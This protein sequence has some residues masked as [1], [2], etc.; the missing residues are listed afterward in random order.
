M[1]DC[2]DTRLVE[3]RPI[4][5]FPAYR[6]GDDGSI[7]SRY[8]REGIRWVLGDDWTELKPT[9]RGEGVWQGVFRKGRY[10]VT[11]CRDGK[12]YERTIHRVILETFVG[13]RPRGM[14]ACHRDDDRDNNRLS[15]LRWDTHRNNI[16]DRGKNG[17]NRP[18]ELNGS[19]K[20]K[21]ADIPD[22]FRLSGQGMYQRDIAKIYG[23]THTLI[24]YVLRR[25]LWK[26]VVI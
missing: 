5:G 7:W 21:E 14:E 8:C 4:P 9:L 26:H 22:I 1:P 6:A 16:A 15:N 3:Y 18:G 19:A 13:P 23:V 2:D 25:R 24:G 10:C 17:G 11:L 20:L 12:H